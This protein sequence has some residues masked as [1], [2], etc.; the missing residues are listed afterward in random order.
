MIAFEILMTP[1]QEIRNSYLDARQEAA[2]LFLKRL[3]QSIHNVILFYLETNVRRREK[4]CLIIIF[5]WKCLP[6][7]FSSNRTFNKDY[8]KNKKQGLGTFCGNKKHIFGAKPIL[9]FRTNKLKQANGA[10]YCVT[11]RLI[12]YFIKPRIWIMSKFSGNL[13]ALVSYFF[14]TR[15]HKI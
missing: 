1:K 15:L 7:P 8:N 14:L 9:Y 4:I 2:F 12:D 11:F 10:L 3:E 13:S 6:K 5:L